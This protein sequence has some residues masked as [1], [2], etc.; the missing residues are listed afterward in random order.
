[1]ESEAAARGPWA[2]VMGE[3]HWVAAT[4]G[5]TQIMNWL[6]R[7]G[8][9]PYSMLMLVFAGMLALCMAH[10]VQCTILCAR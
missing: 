8:R 6:F 4:T 9:T 7:E 10:L 5:L 2:K 1:M 3:E